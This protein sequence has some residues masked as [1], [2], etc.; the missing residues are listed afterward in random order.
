MR[1]I[2]ADALKREM[3]RLAWNLEDTAESLGEG[4]LRKRLNT[5]SEG[6]QRGIDML[7]EQPTIE[8]RKTGRWIKDNHFLKCPICEQTQYAVEAYDWEDGKWTCFLKYCPNCG[9]KLEDA[10]G[11]E[12]K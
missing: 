4:L 10:D 6:V 3:Q 5:I 11:E 12:T 1:L 7:N 9:A 2:D 8:E